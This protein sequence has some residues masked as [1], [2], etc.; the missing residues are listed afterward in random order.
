MREKN[1]SLEIPKNSRPYQF[2][3]TI[4]FLSLSSFLGTLVT[5]QESLTMADE[6]IRHKIT[7]FDDEGDYPDE[8]Q[9]AGEEQVQLEKGFSKV[10]VVDN[11]PVVPTEKYQK[12]MGVITRIYNQVGRHA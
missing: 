2:Q 11:L 12:L 5:T 6:V 9:L 4:G 10:I 3:E 8:Y 7:D 1:P